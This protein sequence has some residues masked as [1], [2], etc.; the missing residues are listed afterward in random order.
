MRQLSPTIEIQGELGRLGSL[1]P[2]DSWYARESLE[3]AKET[4]SK[5]MAI[6]Y[7]KEI[8][9]NPEVSW[10]Q[11]KTQKHLSVFE[12]IP[13]WRDKEGGMKGN[14]LRKDFGARFHEA[15]AFNGG[16]FRPCTTWKVEAPI[17]VVRQWFRSSIYAITEMSRRYTNEKT[18]PYTF[19]GLPEF[20]DFWAM[21]M[22][23]FHRR[24]E[25]GIKLEDARTC[26]PLELMTEF[27]WTGYDMDVLHKADPE[28]EED[29]DGFAL[30][31]TTPHAQDAT[32][33]FASVMK[34]FLTEKNGGNSWL[35]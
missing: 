23:E 7:G 33:R 5:V 32:R 28:I 34:N 29:S 31:R 6:C 3:N 20:Q 12:H 13:V 10:K 25:S 22:D 9:N 2:Y 18:K 8:T 19:Y 15:E 17:F 30:L 35:T 26:M 27:W 24:I 4:V 14:S 21:V 1:T 11:A 16:S